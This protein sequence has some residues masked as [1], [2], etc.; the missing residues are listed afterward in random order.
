MGRDQAY[1]YWTIWVGPILIL[2]E[3]GM[4]ATWWQTLLLSV[5]WVYQ[6]SQRLF[7]WIATLAH[8]KASVYIINIIFI[9]V[10]V[11][12]I[13]NKYCAFLLR[14]TYSFSFRIPLVSSFGWVFWGDWFQQVRWYEGQ[15]FL[16]WPPWITVLISSSYLCSRYP[17]VWLHVF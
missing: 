3:L 6:G 8:L 4:R 1:K 13:P 9:G 2:S 11:T 15:G 12:Q 17:R 5:R 14:R 10:S 16:V 7:P